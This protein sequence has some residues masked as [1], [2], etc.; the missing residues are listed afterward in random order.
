EDEIERIFTPFERLGV[1]DSGIEGTGLGL[2]VS[3]T[4]IE[5]MGGS[6][7]VARSVPG[8]GS[9]FYVELPLTDAPTG[10][11]LGHASDEAPA[12][13]DESRLDGVSVLYIEDNAFNV[14]LV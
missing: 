8:R 4:M 9:M 6:I 1:Q 11:S 13:P 14:E 5:A 3:R 12:A 7:G 2:A 10:A